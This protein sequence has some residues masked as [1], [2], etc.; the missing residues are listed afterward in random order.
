MIARHC[1]R[2]N[3]HHTGDACPPCPKVSWSNSRNAVPSGDN[4]VRFSVVNC[5]SAVVQASADW[6][7]LPY[8][9]SRSASRRIF[10]ICDRPGVHSWGG[11]KSCLRIRALPERWKE[12]SGRIAEI[13]ANPLSW[14][15]I[16]RHTKFAQTVIVKHGVEDDAEWDFSSQLG[17]GGDDDEQEVTS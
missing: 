11:G 10:K 14:E 5:G 17:E 8:S 12:I 7:C 13:L 4:T 2:C 3:S 16:Q 1:A 9:L 15:R 6:W